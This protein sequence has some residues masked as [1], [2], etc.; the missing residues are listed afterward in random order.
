MAVY[1]ANVVAATCAWAHRWK[2]L[3][4]L[5]RVEYA[6]FLVQL[7]VLYHALIK[8]SLSTL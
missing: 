2:R 7:L 8:S 3:F 5:F 4:V 1:Q 6:V